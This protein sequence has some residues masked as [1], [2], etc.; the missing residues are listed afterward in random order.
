VEGPAR[1]VGLGP[2]ELVLDVARPADVL[3]R[4]RHSSHWSLDAPGCV[5]ASEGGWTIVRPEQAGVVTLRPVLARSLP[6]VG[7]LDGCDHTS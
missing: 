2:D 4:V 6:V 1:I 5:R 3:V 7:S